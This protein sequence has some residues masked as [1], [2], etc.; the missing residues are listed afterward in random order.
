[1]ARGR[2]ATRAMVGEFS[3]DPSGRKSTATSRR[4]GLFK[5]PR[6]VTNAPLRIQMPTE[7]ERTTGRF[8]VPSV[9]EG[10]R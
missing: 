6:A 1:M 9:S 10:L 3:P 7:Q 8:E 2:G 4:S 5:G